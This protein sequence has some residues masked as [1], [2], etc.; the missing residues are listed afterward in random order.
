MFGTKFF[1]SIVKTNKTIYEKTNNRI[2]AIL[3]SEYFFKINAQTFSIGPTGGFGHS[4]IHNS[5]GDTKFNPAWNAGLS[6]IYSTKSSFGIGADVK[7]S[8][9]GNKRDFQTTGPADGPIDVTGTINANY[10]RVPL[11]LIYFGANNDNAVRPKIYAG[12][13]FG[14]LTSANEVDNFPAIK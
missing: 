9:E 12:P 4:W 10:I 6:F 13:S 11:K 3:V 2:V 5:D 14:F 1:K 8:A 7:Y